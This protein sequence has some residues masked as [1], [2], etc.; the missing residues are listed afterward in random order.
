MNFI[1]GG[2]LVEKNK[3]DLINLYTGGDLVNGGDLVKA[4]EGD[5]TLAIYP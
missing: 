1:K 3:G 5:L 4:V 2:D